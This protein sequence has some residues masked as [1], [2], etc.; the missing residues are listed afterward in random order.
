MYIL[1]TTL[2]SIKRSMQSSVF[3]VHLD[4]GSDGLCC[5]KSLWCQTMGWAFPSVRNLPSQKSWSSVVSLL[6]QQA[7]IRG[8]K[9][10][11]FLGTFSLK[12]PTVW[13]WHLGVDFIFWA[14]CQLQWNSSNLQPV[15]A[16]GQGPLRS[17]LLKC[18]P[19]ASQQKE[20]FCTFQM[21]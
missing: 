21:S 12:F 8:C 7:L 14:P 11:A 18:M 5:R 4:N 2:L 19:F 9:R 1:V 13:D 16:P 20:G 6:P 17:V 10:K 15:K 3:I